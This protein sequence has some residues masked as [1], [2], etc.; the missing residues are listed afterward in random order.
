MA[1]TTAD[2]NADRRFEVGSLE[3]LQEG[4]IRLVQAGGREIGLIR[5]GEEVFAVRNVCPHVAGPAC[6][7]VRARLRAEPTQRTLIA[8]HERPVLVCSWH[9]WEFDLRSG[10]A[11]FDRRLHVKTYAVHVDCDETI[12]ITI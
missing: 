10:R 1:E 8:D 3:D 11:L 6:G 7:A 4:R 2:T 5:W 9:R 12:W